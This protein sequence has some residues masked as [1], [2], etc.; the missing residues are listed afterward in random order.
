MGKIKD[1]ALQTYR[2]WS[3]YDG[4][5]DSAALAFIFLLSIP[6]L[7][8]FTVSLGSMFVQDQ[9]LQQ[10]I[11]EYA[12]AFATQSTLDMLNSL[13][14]QIPDTSTL[15]LG[16]IISILL[17]LWTAGNLFNQLQKTINGMWHI[18]NRQ[19]EGYKKSIRERISSMLAVIAFVFIIV[20]STVFEVIVL[21]ISRS[22]PSILPLPLD[23]IQY[24]SSILN[25]L[26][27]LLLFIYLYRVLPKTKL[28]MKP[29]L[30][31]AFL[32]VVF[33]T[34]GIHA[35]NLYLMFSNL[36]SVY[37]SI[38]SLIAIFLLIYIT[39]IIVT[40]MA[41]FTKVYA[42]YDNGTAITKE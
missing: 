12:S 22:F 34:I 6:A 29:V 39:A 35:F 5:T 40:V 17:F 25:F 9:A 42:D 14:Q 1:I 32:T 13:F 28:D 36:R 7:L 23:V 2:S 8:L 41:Q 38:G 30:V 37:G 18:D 33:I 4:I 16:L 21:N 11:I 19:N 15:T 31:G 10:R 3:D 27:L 20:I 26:I 24:T